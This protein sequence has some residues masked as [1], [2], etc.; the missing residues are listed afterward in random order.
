MIVA[1]LGFKMTAVPFHFY[2]P[3]VYQGTTTGNAALLAFVPKI[4]GFVALIRVF[5]FVPFEIDTPAVR[6]TGPIEGRDLATLLWIIAAV[7]MTLGNV[8]AL[9]QDNV[10]R[11]LAYS[12]VAHSG[13]ILVGLAA[14]NY[15]QARN[16]G[17]T[18]GIDTVLFYMVAYGAMTVGAFGVLQYLSTRQRPVETV[19]DLAGLS[20]SHPGVALVMALFL[21]S[22]IGIP[23]TPGFSGKFAL[24]FDA[25][26]LP[27]I[28]PD[29]KQ[30]NLF[31]VLALIL[32]LNAAI[33][34]WY[35]L[36]LITVM[37]LRTSVQPLQKQK[38]SPRLV[39]VA[40]CAL[41]TLIFFQPRP[42]FDWAREAINGKVNVAAK[43]GT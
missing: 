12:S 37:Y 22:L 36:R 1:G 43:S 9:L 5:G 27:R 18:R 21:F 34:S 19:D 20:K 32:V 23:P 31:R 40:L 35:Y 39:A 3:D 15:I 7:T 33:A 2:A 29:V 10:K 42:L 24:L 14:A 6:G 17:M 13:Y 41:V 4:A 30:A 28:E 26:S 38:A 8:L 16:P 11:M 25:F